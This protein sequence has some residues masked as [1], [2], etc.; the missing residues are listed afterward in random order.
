V[1]DRLEIF[2]DSGI[3][4]GSDILKALALGARAVLVGRPYCHGLALGGPDGAAAV[5]LNLLS[6]LD[7]TLGLCGCT[8]MDEMSRDRLLRAESDGSIAPDP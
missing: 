2:F 7:L 3:R 5:M 1:G 6:D 8:G 4:R